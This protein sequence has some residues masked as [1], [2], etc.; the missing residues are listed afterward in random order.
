MAKCPKC[1]YEE[2]DVEYI[3]ETSYEDLEVIAFVKASCPKCEAEFYV[4]EFFTF[5]RSESVK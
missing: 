5:T 2:Y 3:E 1:G 4:R